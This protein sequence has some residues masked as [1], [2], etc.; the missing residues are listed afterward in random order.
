MLFLG[1]GGDQLCHVLVIKKIGENGIVDV[2]YGTGQPYYSY[3]EFAGTITKNSKGQ[4]LDAMLGN[5]TWVT[6][7]L[8][9]IAGDNPT[10]LFEGLYQGTTGGQF[11]PVGTNE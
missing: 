4:Q 11:K 8:I 6:Y 9:T 5:G 2:V 1:Y 10:Y 7:T 3:G